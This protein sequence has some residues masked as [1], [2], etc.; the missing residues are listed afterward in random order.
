MSSQAGRAEAARS[1]TGRCDRLW[2]PKDMATFWRD[3]VRTSMEPVLFSAP[4]H[5][6]QHRLQCMHRQELTPVCLRWNC[7]FPNWQLL[8]CCRQLQRLRSTPTIGE[9]HS[10]YAWKEKIKSS[11]KNTQLLTQVQLQYQLCDVAEL[12]KPRANLDQKIL[13]EM[14]CLAHHA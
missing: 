5:L 13:L 1:V 14:C 12:C 4:L 3:Y 8:V 9:L 6:A 10:K 11:G 2:H 7:S